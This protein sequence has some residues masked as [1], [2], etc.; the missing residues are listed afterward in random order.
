[1]VDVIFTHEGTVNKFVGDMI[2]S[3]FGAPNKLVDSERKAIETA[4]AMQQRLRNFPGDWIRENFI[5]GIGISSGEVIVGNIGSPQHMDYT[6][7]G[8]QVNVASRLQSIAQ[9]GQIL[10]SRSIYDL[11][12]ELFDFKE[13]GFVKVKGKKTKVE[14]FEVIY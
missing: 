10:V 11:T 12:Q 14:I 8:D 5:T 13:V 6:A 1:M 3:M 4:I 7:I 9:G 2:V